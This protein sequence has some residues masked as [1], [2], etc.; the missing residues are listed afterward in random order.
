MCGNDDDGKDDTKQT[1]Q[2]FLWF[3]IPFLI[4]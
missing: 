1:K 3:Y 2:F 4:L